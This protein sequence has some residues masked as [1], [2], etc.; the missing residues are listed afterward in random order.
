M[1]ENTSLPLYCLPYFFLAGTEKS[2]TSDFFSKLTQHPHV[3]G[4]YRK[5][6]QWFNSQNFP[7]Y[8]GRVDGQ[9]S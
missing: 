3:F 7:L 5:E 8:G 9:S 6:I 2:G 4:G 1:R